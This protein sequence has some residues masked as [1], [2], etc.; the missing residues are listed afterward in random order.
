EHPCWCSMQVTHQ[1]AVPI[2]HR[3]LHV[4]HALPILLAIAFLVGIF[5]V[6][7]YGESW[8]ELQFFKYADRALQA[9]ATWPTTGTIPLTGNTYDNYGPAYVMLVALGARLLA[10]VLPWLTSDL[11][12]LLYFITYL[13]AIW[14]FHTLARRWLSVAAALG[15]T[16]LFSTQ[17][18]FWGHAFISPK[19]IPFLAFFLLSLE[20]GLRMVDAVPRLSRG[21]LPAR[22]RRR[23]AWLTAGWAALLV[24]AYTATPL[25]RDAVASTVSSAATGHSNLLS[26]VTSRITMQNSALYI[27]RFF[28]GLLWARA[29]FF[30]ITA[31]ILLWLW[32]QSPSALRFLLLIVP[33]AILLGVT[34]SIRVV[35]P[36]AGL[37]VAAYAVW[38]M[39]KA[40]AVPLILYAFIAGVAMYLTWP[41]LWPNPL[42]HL[43]ESVRVM[44]QYPWQGQVLFNGASYAS[45]DLPRSYLPML[46]G[47]QLTEPVWPLFAIGFAISVYEAIQRNGRSR[48]LLVLAGAWFILPLL[49]FVITRSPLYDNFRQV[50]FILPP[51]FV[52]AG[53]A[54]ERVRRPALQAALIGLL[55]L[56]GIVDG[57]RLHPYE[58]IYYNHFI[59]GVQGAFRRFELDYWGTSYREA[60]DYVNAVAPA[61]ATVWIEGPAHLFQLYARPDLKTYSTY[62]ADRADHYDYVVALSRYD[63]DL[64]AYP[65]AAVVHVIQRDGATLTVI[66]KP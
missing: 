7:Q 5:T 2:E 47:I 12:H 57:I 9:Y 45:T 17:P 14:A 24:L 4:S 35:G 65:D 13:A 37:M 46:L 33:A 60:A 29:A 54:F 3:G 32:R 20:F 27:Q 58:Y 62:E 22:T 16:L 51:V 26:L 34:T 15:A 1:Q 63:L 42:G 23:L 39:G 44:S 40:A 36:F 56:P 52:V 30:L 10:L 28:V 6:R 8:D 49:G 59:G 21:E 53:L 66:K 38:K 18:L 19:D 25:F 48:T 31:I 64:T 11:R 43:V 41:Y 61:N 55:V 50:I